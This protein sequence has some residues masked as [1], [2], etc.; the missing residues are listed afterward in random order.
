MAIRTQRLVGFANEA[1]VLS[2]DWDDATGNVTAVRCVNG[3]AR[4]VHVLVQGTGS[5]QAGRSREATFGTG[6]TVINIPGGQ[7]PRYP[8]T[9]NP[10]TGTPEI[11][12]YRMSAEIL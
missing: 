2:F 12:G 7:Q 10:D 4:S 5:G 11:A 8:V 3:T 1:I 6:T 9:A